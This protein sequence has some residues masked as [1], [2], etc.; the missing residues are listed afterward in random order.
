MAKISWSMEAYNAA[1]EALVKP[2]NTKHTLEPL[3]SFFSA[4]SFEQPQITILFN[5]KPHLILV[6]LI[7]MLLKH[8]HKKDKQ[9]LSP[10]A[11]KLS[12]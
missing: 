6:N 11:L 4:E 5:Q 7:H 9:E 10:I 3:C 8:L 12:A 1:L 2:H